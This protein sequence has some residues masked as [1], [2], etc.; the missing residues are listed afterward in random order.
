MNRIVSLEIGRRLFYWFEILEIKK[1]T[2][3]SK[4]GREEIGVSYSI[5]NESFI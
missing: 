5:S 2:V 4:K 3:V 1:K